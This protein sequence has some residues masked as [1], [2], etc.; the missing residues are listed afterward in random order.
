MRPYH[1]PQSVDTRHLLRV[2]GPGRPSQLN[3][4]RADDRFRGEPI[5]R[6][7]IEAIARPP[8]STS[9]GSTCASSG[10]CS[11]PP[12]RG[13]TAECVGIGVA[14]RRPGGRL[15]CSHCDRAVRSAPRARA[16]AG[17]P[18]IPTPERRRCIGPFPAARAAMA[19][20]LHSCLQH[21]DARL[22]PVAPSLAA[23]PV[24]SPVPLSA[25][26]G[27]PADRRRGSAARGKRDGGRARS[28]LSRFT[29]VFLQRKRIGAISRV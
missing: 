7:S 28:R 8:T 21:P 25:R 12:A 4:Q 5:V 2:V 23:G 3:E 1:G 14:E 16:I 15:L 20:L 11:R 19:A 18:V 6:C 29:R 13:T 24:G 9:R 17:R 26:S 22:A 27:A 10:P